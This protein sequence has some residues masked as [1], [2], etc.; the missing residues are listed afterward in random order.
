MN[1]IAEDVSMFEKTKNTSGQMG[2]AS[3][4]HNMKHEEDPKQTILNDLGDLSGL[5][6]SGAQILVATY[7][8]PE[9]MKSGLIITTN[10]REEDKFQGKCGLVIKMGPL[11]YKETEKLD[12]GGYRVK[13]G[14]WVW[15]RPMDGYALSV[16]GVHCRVLDDVEIRGDVTHP[17]LVV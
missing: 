12:F 3:P 1:N 7:I 15:Y 13:E 16:K 4:L 8:R 14:D 10:T 11:A 6:L 17:D 9:R 5:N 2:C